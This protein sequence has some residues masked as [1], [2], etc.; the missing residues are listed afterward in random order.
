MI[1]YP[2]TREIIEAAEA[3]AELLGKLDN[4][5]RE[6]EGNLVGYIGEFVAN[7]FIQGTLTTEEPE[8]YQYDIYKTVN[9]NLVTFD[10]KT[11]ERTVSPKHD[12]D[13]SVAN[14]NTRQNC[15]YYVFVSVLN[16]AVD[17]KNDPPIYTNA[18]IL[19]TMSKNDYYRKARYLTKG[20][21]DPSN[22][23][24]VKADCYNMAVHDLESLGA[25]LNP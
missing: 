5:I 18:W 21:I 22:N 9:E 6:G 19:G 23:Y 13:C 2:V 10:V 16:K 15:D 11:K 1:A 14:F 20:M 4:S 24:E 7:C 17:H 3:R 12:Y 8:V 25:V